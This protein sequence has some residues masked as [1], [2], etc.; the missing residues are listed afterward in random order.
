MF[1]FERHVVNLSVGGTAA[2][3]PTLGGPRLDEHWKGSILAPRSDQISLFS[4]VLLQSL[5]S[6]QT[7]DLSTKDCKAA[8]FCRR[9]AETSGYWHVRTSLKS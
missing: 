4:L 8:I 3:E 9:T 1:C 7:T 6:E 2:F 5:M